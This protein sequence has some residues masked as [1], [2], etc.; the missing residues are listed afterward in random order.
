MGARTSWRRT[1]GTTK[2][3]GG[4]DPVA[5][6][7]RFVMFGGGTAGAEKCVEKANINEGDGP[8]VKAVAKAV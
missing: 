7:Q 6:G 2:R 5:L 1:T 4:E 8:V 3:W